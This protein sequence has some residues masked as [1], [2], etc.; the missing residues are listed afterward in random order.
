MRIYPMKNNYRLITTLRDALAE[1]L[2]N[3]EP[4]LSLRTL[5]VGDRQ[6][7]GFALTKSRY[8]I[9]VFDNHIFERTYS[10]VFTIEVRE[11]C[12]LL[13]FCI[14]LMPKEHE[15]MA[16]SKYVPLLRSKIYL[17]VG[18]GEIGGAHYAYS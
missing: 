15:R 3:R 9:A 8:F 11:D 1:E 2:E 10:V 5:S 12:Y 18:L 16:A 4:S 14:P 17:S 6:R 7:Q 13:R